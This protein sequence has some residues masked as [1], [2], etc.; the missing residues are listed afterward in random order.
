MPSDS[1]PDDTTAKPT[2]PQGNGGAT[3][4]P[5]PAP[6]GFLQKPGKNAPEC[7][8][9][10]Y[11]CE[12][13]AKKHPGQTDPNCTGPAAMGNEERCESTWYALKYCVPYYP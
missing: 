2:S 6:A 3:P 7:V 10:A 5:A 8:W 1:P 13:E 9:L 11:C 4:A 12:Q